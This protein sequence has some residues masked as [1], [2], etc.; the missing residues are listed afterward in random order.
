VAT[1]IIFPV[2]CNGVNVAAR[3]TQPIQSRAILA[4]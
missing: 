2:R 4:R 1:P 3:T